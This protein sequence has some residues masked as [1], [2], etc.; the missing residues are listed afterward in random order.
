MTTPE[1][2]ASP[3]EYGA[4][5]GSAGCDHVWHYWPWR[6]D[7]I[8]S[9]FACAHVQVLDD[10]WVDTGCD[11][12]TVRKLWEADRSIRPNVSLEALRKLCRPRRGFRSR[13]RGFVRCLQ[14]LR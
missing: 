13:L 14:S 11:S 9:C 2:Q 12:E 1:T 7:V 5:T 8:R 10:G 6:V 4:A 3:P